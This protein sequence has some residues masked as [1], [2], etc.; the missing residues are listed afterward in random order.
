MVLDGS[1]TDPSWNPLGSTVDPSGILDGSNLD[2][3]WNHLGSVMDLSWILNGPILGP[4]RNIIGS[5]SYPFWINDR[6]K[7]DPSWNHIGS[8]VVKFWILEG[9]LGPVLEPYWFL[10]GSNV[11]PWMDSGHPGTHPVCYGVQPWIISGFIL[12]H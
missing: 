8:C 6:S 10:S 9:L 7:L 5:F 3:T 11:D 12:N 2:P 1:N 4:F